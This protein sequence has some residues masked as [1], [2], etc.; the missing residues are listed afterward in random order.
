M[1]RPAV[2]TLAIGHVYLRLAIAML[3]SCRSFLGERA[4]YYVFYTDA[5]PKL[6]EIPSYVQLVRIARP[7]PLDTR[8]AARRY[9]YVPLT[10]YRLRFRDVL[11]LDADVIAYHDTLSPI[12]RTIEQ[13]SMLLAGTIAP[14]LT[15][16]R[17]EEGEF[18]LGATTD[19]NGVPLEDMRINSGLIGRAA[20]KRGR[21]F[22]SIMKR[23][24]LDLSFF[25]FVGEYFN[26]EPYV[27]RAYQMA[28]RE[29]GGGALLGDNKKYAT[30]AAGRFSYN[31]SGQP[32]IHKDTLTDPIE[33]PGIVHFVGFT[34]FPE[35]L[36]LVEEKVPLRVSPAVYEKHLAGRDL[37]TRLRKRIERERKK[38]SRRHSG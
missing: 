10:H 11:F 33:N 3:K 25:P 17:G 4:V 16:P 15:W 26:D 2:T 29:L 28:A 20:N 12:L 18:G 36:E 1:F 31:E 24:L 9:K 38:L 14:G 30:T 27:A 21:R 5:N 34:Q 37:P 6:F 35:Y 32:V 8:F 19:N 22:A 7:I 23:E 13:S